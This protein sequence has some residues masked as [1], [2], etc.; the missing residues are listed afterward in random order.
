MSMISAS[1]DSKPP[2]AE[3]A[4]YEEQVLKEIRVV[5]ETTKVAKKEKVNSKPSFWIRTVGK[6]PMT[7]M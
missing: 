2:E 4:A 3:E 7:M 6:W 5:P 1:P